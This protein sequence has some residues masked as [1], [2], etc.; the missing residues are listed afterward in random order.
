MYSRLKDYEDLTKKFLEIS[1][2]SGE[3]FDDTPLRV[4]KFWSEFLRPE[5]P[6]TKTFPCTNPFESVTLSNYV[7][8][9]MCPH[10]LLP[11]KYTVS[12]SYMPTERVVGISKLPRVVDYL[13]KHLPLQEDFPKLV[14]DFLWEILSP[15][16]V[17]C[18]ITGMHLCMVMRGVKAPEDCSLTTTAKKWRE[19]DAVSGK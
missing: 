19:R 12:I 10:H 6:P 9:G 3:N 15:E 14:V 2:L 11:V 7:T 5:E 18:T 8:W 16:Y 13:K 1:K 4:A 17:E